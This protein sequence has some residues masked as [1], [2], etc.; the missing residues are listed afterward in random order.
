MT[1]FYVKDLVKT[2]SILINKKGGVIMA[3]IKK[4]NLL[5]VAL[6][7]YI[8]VVI[9]YG[10][11]FLLAPQLLVKASGSEQVAS[12]WLRWPG[13]VLI[14]LGVGAFMVYRNPL[15]QYVF[16]LTIALGTL[17]SGLALLYALLFEMIGDTWFTALP[18]IILLILTA[19]LW[20]GSMQAKDILLPK[21]EE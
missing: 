3:K 4:T 2:I 12:S 15:K 17:L 18:V 16:I 20:I 1:L 10:V 19:L 8:V 13:G 14:A 11:L 7:I 21:E 6:I 5:N 9:V